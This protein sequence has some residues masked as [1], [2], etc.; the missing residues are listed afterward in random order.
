MSVCAASLAN[1]SANS[2][3]CI[4]TWALTHENSYQPFQTLQGR[5]PLRKLFYEVGMVI[6]V[7]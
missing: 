4:P 5:H 1:L 7:L 3:P 2:F 6:S